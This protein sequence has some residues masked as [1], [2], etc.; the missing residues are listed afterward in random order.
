LAATKAAYSPEEKLAIVSQ[1]AEA[2]AEGDYVSTWCKKLGV[3]KGRLFEWCEAD[4]T[5]RNLYARARLAQAHALAE[6]TLT[7]ADDAIGG[8]EGDTDKVRLQ[9]DTRKW[10]TSKIA[11]RFYGEKLELTGDPERPLQVQVWQFGKKEVE[12]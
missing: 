3:S 2:I 10:Y 12:F 5:L 1:I 8:K 4:E 6:Q 9:V 7:L 11:P